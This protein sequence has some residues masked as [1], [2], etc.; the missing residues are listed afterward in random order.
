MSLLAHLPFGLKLEIEGE[1][2]TVENYS[3]CPWTSCQ[4]KNSIYGYCGEYNVGM[5]DKA[6]KLVDWCPV[7]L[8]QFKPHD[9]TIRVREHYRRIILEKEINEE[10]GESKEVS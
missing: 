3:V 8:M 5:K 7:D 1:E 4:F 10:K 2:R 6:G 9:N